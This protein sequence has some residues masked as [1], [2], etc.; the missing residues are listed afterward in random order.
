MRRIRR[1]WRIVPFYVRQFP[2]GCLVD[3]LLGSAT[4]TR[5]ADCVFLV[6]VPTATHRL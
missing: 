6:R 1:P 4:Q 2:L 5:R 3:V